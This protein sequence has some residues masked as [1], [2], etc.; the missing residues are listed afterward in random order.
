MKKIK[1]RGSFNAILVIIHMEFFMF[2]SLTKATRLDSQSDVLTAD[3]SF[4]LTSK[5]YNNSKLSH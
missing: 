5:P 4:F 1:S 2:K 3:S